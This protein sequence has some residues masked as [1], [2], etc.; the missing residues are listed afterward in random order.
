LP[1]KSVDERRIAIKGWVYSPYRMND[2]MNE[3]LGSWD[4]PQGRR[5]RMKIFDDDIVSSK[6]QLYDSQENE[7]QLSKLKPNLSIILPLIFNGKH[8]T[9]LFEQHN[10]ELNILSGN[11]RL[12]LISGILISLL[13]FILSHALIN[14][15][16]RT[17]QILKL[18][19][20]LE[21]HISD[22]DRYISI[23][24]HDLKSPFNVILGFLSLLSENIHKYTIDKIESQVSIINSSA[25]RIYNLLEEIL[26][27]ARSQSGKLPFEP[28]K[29]NFI[30]IC[31]EITGDFKVLAEAKNIEI[32]CICEN[33]VLVF[34]DVN[35]FKT[36]MRNLISNAIKFTK[37]EGKINVSAVQ[38]KIETIVSVSDNGIGIDQTKLES[39]FIFSQ[40]ESS[41]GTANEKGTGL[42]L[43]LCKDLVEKQGGSIWVVSEPAKGSNFS[44]SIPFTQDEKKD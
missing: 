22:K 44:F 31:A 35:I 33:E 25:K 37:N 4:L 8:W 12:V 36:I 17:K 43:L 1:V 16:K 21:K 19:S 9:L 5:I 32:N 38:N 18:N 10:P 42:G 23:L 2:L 26:L 7:P 34:V 41:P 15:Q 24:A 30:D 3:I 11:S 20:E 29:I 28:Q 39:L 6:S 13:L 14:S 40:F 27:W